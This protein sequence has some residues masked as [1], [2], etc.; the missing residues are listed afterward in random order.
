M[1]RKGP[2]KTMV[3]VIGP[4]N[5]FILLKI[6]PSPTTNRTAD[7]ASHRKKDQIKKIK[8]RSIKKASPLLNPPPLFVGFGNGEFSPK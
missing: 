1:K 6:S 8:T 3:K 4:K 5:W 7:T 2:R